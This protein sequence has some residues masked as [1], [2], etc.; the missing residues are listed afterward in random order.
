ML[1][2]WNETILDW[3]QTGRRFN[4]TLKLIPSISYISYGLQQ[5]LLPGYFADTKRTNISDIDKLLK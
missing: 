3:E 4:N 1:W 2:S 5:Y